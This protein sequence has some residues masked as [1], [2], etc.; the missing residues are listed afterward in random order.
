LKTRHFSVLSIAILLIASCLTFTSCGGDAVDDGMQVTESFGPSLQR[1][2]VDTL[3]A[4]MD[5]QTR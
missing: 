5:V 3:N 1:G 2:L 4:V